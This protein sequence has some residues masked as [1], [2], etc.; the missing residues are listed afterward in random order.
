M[1]RMNLRRV[2]SGPVTITLPSGW[3]PAGA[4]SQVRDF[5]SSAKSIQWAG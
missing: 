3:T 1:L 5:A 2:L 4:T